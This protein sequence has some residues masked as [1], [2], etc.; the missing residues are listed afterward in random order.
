MKHDQFVVRREKEAAKK[1]VRLQTVLKTG[2]SS[3]YELAKISPG[4]FLVLRGG[5]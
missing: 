4:F 5:R 1:A 3:G 2:A